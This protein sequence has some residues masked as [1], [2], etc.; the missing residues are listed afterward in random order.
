MTALRRVV[1]VGGGIAGLTAADSLRA[2]GF[3]GELTIV[4]A[5]RRAAYSRPALSKALLRAEAD[6]TAHEL[7]PHE[8]GAVEL[9]GVAA[10][11]LD[12]ATR[13]VS[14]DD[15]GAL[16]YDGL[17]IA[18]G[19]RARRLGAADGEHVL[20][21][22][23][24]AIA[25]RARIA[26]R[27][28]VIVVGGGPLGMEVASGAL[29]AGCAVTLVTAG[30]P[31]ARHLGAHLAAR[32]ER[33]ALARGLTIL[34]T[35]AARILPG[36]GASAVAL[37]DGTLVEGDLLVS[38]VGDIPNTGWL[39]GSGLDAAMRPDGAIAVDARARVRPEIVAAGDV[40]AVPTLGGHARS[41][42][43]HSAID[44]ARIAAV[45]LLRGDES[46]TLGGAPYFWTEQFGLTIRVVGRTPVDGEPELVDG[47][48]EG[49]ALLRWPHADGTATAAAVDYRIPIPRLRRL[50]DVAA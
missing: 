4:G 15:G 12:P 13:M 38:G 2:S 29:D 24:D 35:P 1:V 19:S 16:P 33:T 26:D 40:A 31:M 10:T 39:A 11:G 20:R 27:P 32:L 23:D 25:L 42:I 5:E 50:T 34:R 18:S 47:D 7:P 21:T 36:A 6:L 46:P 37:A 44:Q 48:P 14:L 3:D 49:A 45:S 30:A 17:V 28:S 22:L 8:H 43:W 41:P 9:L